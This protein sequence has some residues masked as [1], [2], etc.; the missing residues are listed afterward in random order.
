M[1]SKKKLFENIE[2]I[3]FRIILCII[4][5]YSLLTLIFRSLF[6]AIQQK[7]INI[8]IGILSYFSIQTDILIAL[9]LTFS[10]IYMNKEKKPIFLHP[11]VLGAITV[12]ASFTFLVFVFILQ[13]L[14]Q[15]IIIDV[16]H[17]FI[18]VFFIIHWF[19]IKPK[20]E[21]KKAYALYWLIYPTI[22]LFYIFIGGILTNKFPY[23]FLDLNLINPLLYIINNILIVGFF[24]LLG[25]IFIFIN[26]KSIIK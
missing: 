10:L 5:W 2:I 24:Y 16:N 6:Y 9:W 22:Y 23:P 13:P 18:P 4:S 21:Y 7:N 1:D 20:N 12:Y 14:E 3:I 15:F 25:R 17:Y 8:F 19:Y 11:S 26:Q